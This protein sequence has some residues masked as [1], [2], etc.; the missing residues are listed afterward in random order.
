MRHHVFAAGFSRHRVGRDPTRHSSNPSLTR[1]IR[2]GWLA[3]A[4]VVLLF[5]PAGGGAT[6]RLRPVS[7]AQSVVEGPRTAIGCSTYFGGAAEDF[8][9]DVAIDDDGFI[10]L[11]G[12]TTSANF[13]AHLALQ[14]NLHGVQD[15][16]VA[17]LDPSGTNVIFATYLGGSSEDS[18]SGIDVADD[19]TII[20]VGSTDSADFPV[21]DPLMTNPDEGLDDAFIVKLAADGSQVLYS[22]YLG[23]LQRDGAVAVA[24]SSDGSVFVTGTTRSTDFPVTPGVFQPSAPEVDCSNGQCRNVFVSKLA[25]DGALLAYSTYL[26]GSRTEEP[27]DIAVDADGHAFVTGWANS[28]DFPTRDAAQPANGGGNCGTTDNPLTCEDV[29][30][31][32]FAADGS[33]LEYSTLLGG[34]RNDRGYEIEVAS[35]G[36]AY[37]AGWAGSPDFPTVNAIQSTFGG[38]DSDAIV[39]ALDPSG[40]SVRFA[41]FLGGSD[42]D[43]AYGL[44]LGPS[45]AIIVTGITFSH[46][47]PVANAFDDSFGQTDAWVARLAPDGTALVYS[48]FLGGSDIDVGMAIAR[49]PSVSASVVVG[50]T[51][52]SNF[53]VES[54]IQS[55]YGGDG[56]AFLTVIPDVAAAPE[57]TAIKPSPSGKP[58]KLTLTGSHF[59][60]GLRVYIG[61]SG[62]SWANTAVKSGE[63]VLLKGGNALRTLFPKGQ[64]VSIRLVNPDTGETTTTFTR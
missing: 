37:V 16:F 1:A 17:K 2:C 13:P 57:V 25:P 9:F 54:A 28:A 31:T 49:A 59:Q 8:V 43:D 61:G 24:A 50:V 10:Y 33:S 35:D 52:S 3:I 41:T 46:D 7:P 29:F 22:T 14:P 44:A 30:V 6:T 20:V 42:L 47:F 19:G 56:D 26:G 53:P 5:I 60:N 62:E 32:K 18:G 11:T 4:A 36:T 12:S 58:F 27:N 51:F 48:S 55:V 21:R 39:L 23:G 63:K 15:A 34:T 38:L 64:S 45:D 40:S